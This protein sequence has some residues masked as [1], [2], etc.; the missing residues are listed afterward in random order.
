MSHQE[1]EAYYCATCKLPYD[2]QAQF[3]EHLWSMLHHRVLENNG[4]KKDH[5][6]IL[7]LET[8]PTL[9]DYSVHLI[10]SKHRDAHGRWQQE[11]SRSG[12]KMKKESHRSRWDDHTASAGQGRSTSHHRNYSYTSYYSYKNHHRK[13]PYHRKKVHHGSTP[14]GSAPS[15]PYET[16]LFGG[17]KRGYRSKHYSDN[18]TYY[19]GCQPDWKQSD[20]R[21]DRLFTDRYGRSAV[22]MSGTSKAHAMNR[23]EF[24]NSQHFSMDGRNQRTFKRVPDTGRNC[25]VRSHTPPER[26]LE[27]F[28]E[29]ITLSQI[30]S[31]IDFQHFSSEMQHA[32]SFVDPNKGVQRPT[33]KNFDEFDGRSNNFEQEEKC[34]RSNLHND[35]W[36]PELMDTEVIVRNDSRLVTTKESALGKS[37]LIVHVEVNKG[38]SECSSHSRQENEKEVESALVQEV[39]TRVV[40]SVESLNRDF[41]GSKKENAGKSWEEIQHEGGKRRESD[42]RFSIDGSEER[43]DR[44]LGKTKNDSIVNKSGIGITEKV[45]SSVA[46]KI[47]DNVADKSQTLEARRQ[48]EQNHLD[49]LVNEGSVPSDRL[50][51]PSQT[52]SVETI[53]AHLQTESNRS[54]ED[55]S[56]ISSESKMNTSDSCETKNSGSPKQFSETHFDNCDNDMLAPKLQEKRDTEQPCDNG[57]D[58]ISST[59]LTQSA[60]CQK[61]VGKLSE[62][63]QSHGAVTFQNSQMDGT[64]ASSDTIPSSH[65]PNGKVPPAFSTISSQPPHKTLEADMTQSALSVSN[66]ISLSSVSN[67]NVLPASSTAFFGPLNATLG[68]CLT[69]NSQ[70]GGT[71][72]CSGAV[73]SSSVPIGNVPPAFSTI[74]SQP[75]HK[76]LGADMTQN[77]LSVSNTIPLSSVSSDNG[78]PASS[79][80]SSGPLNATSG[81]C[82]TQNSQIVGTSVCSDTVPSSPVPIGKV[83]SASSTISSQPPHKTLEMGI[84]QN[85]MS[86]SGT[87]L[88]SSVSSDIVPSASSTASSG[89]LNATSLACSTQDS[90]M[91][92]PCTSAF[93]GSLPLSTAPSGMSSQ[94]SSTISSVTP[95]RTSLAGMTPSGEILS[96]SSSSDTI[97]SS[98][99]PNG[100]EQTSST[101]T[102][103]QSNKTSLSV[104]NASQLKLPDLIQKLLK[105]QLSKPNL[106]SARSSHPCESSGVATGDLKRVLLGLFE[107]PVPQHHR[108]LQEEQL[109]KLFAK[110]GSSSDRFKRFG[111]HLEMADTEEDEMIKVLEKLTEEDLEL[112]SQNESHDILHELL[113]LYEVPSEVPSDQSLQAETS[114]SAIPSSVITPSLTSSSAT[115]SPVTPSSIAPSAM[116]SSSML[117]SSLAPKTVSNTLQIQECTDEATSANPKGAIHVE[118]TEELVVSSESEEEDVEALPKPAEIDQ[119][120]FGQVFQL[121]CEENELRKQL[122]STRKELRTL[123]NKIKEL[124]QK[125]NELKAKKVET[126]KKIKAVKKNRLKLTTDHVKQSTQGVSQIASGKD[127]TAKSNSQKK[128]PPHLPECGA[129]SVL[130]TAPQEPCHANIQATV[131]VPQ[132]PV[133]KPG[134]RHSLSGPDH[135]KQSTQ[136]VSQIPS[137]KDSTAKSS[138]K[139]KQP[140]RLPRG[141]AVPAT[142]Q[143][144]P[145]HSNIQATVPGPQ[146]PVIKPGSQHSLSGPS[147]NQALP[148]QHIGINSP[149]PIPSSSALQTSGHNVFNPSPLARVGPNYDNGQLSIPPEAMGISI[150]RISEEEVM[151]LVHGVTQNLS[152]RDTVTGERSLD[153]WQQPVREGNI[154]YVQGGIHQEGSISTQQGPLIPDRFSQAFGYFSHGAPH[155]MSRIL[156][157][158]LHEGVSQPQFTRTQQQQDHASNQMLNNNTTPVMVN[159]VGVVPRGQLENRSSANPVF[160]RAADSDTSSLSPYPVG[161]IKVNSKQ[162][163]LQG[164]PVENRQNGHKQELSGDIVKKTSGRNLEAVT[165]KEEPADENFTA[166]QTDCSKQGLHGQSEPQESVP[167]CSSGIKDKAEGPSESTD[168][169]ED[170]VINGRVLRPRIKLR[171]FSVRCEDIRVRTRKGRLEDLDATSQLPSSKKLRTSVTSEKESQSSTSSK[172]KDEAKKERTPKDDRKTSN[173]IKDLQELKKK[174]KLERKK[175]LLEEKRQKHLRTLESYEKLGLSEKFMEIAKQWRSA[176]KKDR[177]ALHA[178]VMRLQEVRKERAREKLRNSGS[179]KA[180]EGTANANGSMVASS[181]RITDVKGREDESHLPLKKVKRLAELRSIGIP[182]NL[183][184]IIKKGSNATNAE[185]SWLQKNLEKYSKQLRRLK[186]RKRQ[187][188]RKQEKKASQKQNRLD[189]EEPSTSGVVTRNKSKAS[190]NNLTTAVNDTAQEGTPGEHSLRSKGKKQFP[191][192]QDLEKAILGLYGCFDKLYAYS[193]DGSTRCLSLPD[194]KQQTI[195]SGHQKRVTG[196]H[197]FNDTNRNMNLLFTSSED[198]KLFCF[199]LENNK[200]L[201]THTF[202]Y[203]INCMVG[204][205]ESLFLGLP[206]GCVEVF[207]AQKLLSYESY[208]CHNTEILCLAIAGSHSFV[209]GAT[210]GSLAIHS[211]SNGNLFGSL[212]GHQ[213]S[214][215]SVQVR[216]N[217]VLSGASDGR[218]LQHDIV[219]KKLLKEYSGH[220]GA[221]TDILVLRNMFCT[222]CLDDTVRVFNMKG[223]HIV[224]NVPVDKAFSLCLYKQQVYVGTTSGSVMPLPSVSS[225]KAAS[226]ST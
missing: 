32:T 9:T 57:S 144:G 109:K 50:E 192:Y 175:R 27:S 15:L 187:K 206:N 12:P 118:Q 1:K 178:E 176:K 180:T 31:G 195:F 95:D 120:I 136:G 16:G 184:D 188:R 161:I 64:S 156:S 86:V 194:F 45:E 84:T 49:M 80:A 158:E 111:V 98:N 155:P 66:T 207:H 65:I 4:Q 112:L 62:G 223:K 163:P 170:G 177:Q 142:A 199:N 215:L 18:G 53:H 13:K 119:A 168:L 56:H 6:C 201:H 222:A 164:T 191:S 160:P 72:V 100:K 97:A 90:Q 167:S 102:S 103:E 123:E 117:S 218:L 96:T 39:P 130:G 172:K 5:F 147:M 166:D 36:Q 189:L 104:T 202:K 8:Y 105:K 75:P 101:V 21:F 71:S 133:I 214:V 93:L 28:S 68:A 157:P 30:D 134:S 19:S 60:V 91:S 159:Q 203:P 89:P 61:C 132:L 82:L 41:T 88:S 23:E 198:Q 52:E 73:P 174:L 173:T 137:G 135:A 181:E 224:A 94:V 10:S 208:A 74:S 216:G 99:T 182:E 106:N 43:N 85:A 81:A 17:A 141:A 200:L 179:A 165:I 128:R 25:Y 169:Q 51:F 124:T 29:D 145:C 63:K 58:S 69:Q 121:S 54:F 34:R 186:D 92:P 78:P 33:N 38:C 48:E 77:A 190:G 114:F 116:T 153:A 226:S 83:P 46:E 219:S 125:A 211:V 115:L 79:T 183:L 131:P 2:S 221:I 139:K 22:E 14:S 35:R 37:S 220:Q 55:F 171:K 47:Y 152:Q 44:E 197:L 185:S 42:S 40:A 196:L 151:Q 209:S 138:T 149:V 127:S 87:V 213:S 212:K 205:G 129:A 217:N 59:S 70:I 7:C 154:P 26:S 76:T 20:H 225:D 122:K 3:N 110:A 126:K 67:D 113:S 143:Q 107:S 204:L 150:Q 146:L 148:H 140:S 162:Q 210:D 24:N 108:K 11:Q 193:G